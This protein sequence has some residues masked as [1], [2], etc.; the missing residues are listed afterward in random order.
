[1]DSAYLEIKDDAREFLTGVGLVAYSAVL[2]EHDLIWLLAGLAKVRF[3]RARALFYSTS[4][5]KARLDMI[6]SQ[7]ALSGIP[8]GMQEAVKKALDQSSGL[9]DRRNELLHGE[10]VGEMGE[11]GSLPKAMML[12]IRKTATQRPVRDR[13]VS[14]TDVWRLVE[15]YSELSLLLTE[16]SE[17]IRAPHSRGS[18]QGKYPEPQLSAPRQTNSQTRR[19]ERKPPPRS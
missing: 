14:T 18:W 19:R 6:R 11:D 1:M 17:D 9:A 8:A 12:R 13:P 16:L 4:S 2:I 5:A 3:E 10:L 7:V 15:D